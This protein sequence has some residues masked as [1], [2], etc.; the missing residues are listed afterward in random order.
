MEKHS[1][2]LNFVGIVELVLTL[3]QKVQLGKIFLWVLAKIYYKTAEIQFSFIEFLFIVE[4]KFLDEINKKKLQ[5][6]ISEK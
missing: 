3:V 6:L 2:N 5:N 1:F 4:S